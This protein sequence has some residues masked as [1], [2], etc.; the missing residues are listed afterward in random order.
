MTMSAAKF[1]QQCLRVMEEVR[2]NRR[3]V[4]ITKRGKPVAR[5]APIQNNKPQRLLGYL[6]GQVTIQGNIVKPIKVKWGFDKEHV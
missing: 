2:R 5:L 3:E 1:K 6:K 4:V